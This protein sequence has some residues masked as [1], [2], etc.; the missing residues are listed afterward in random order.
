VSALPLVA[1]L[2]AC[3][4]SDARQRARYLEAMELISR[5]PETAWARCAA[6]RDPSLAGDCALSAVEAMAAG[7][8]ESTADLLARCARL[9]EARDR[10]ECAFQVGERRD[11]PEACAAAGAFADDCRLHLLSASM[12][13]W[14]PA[15]TGPADP[16]GLAALAQQTHRVGLPEGDLRAASAMFRALLDRQPVLDRGACLPLASPWREAC[17]HTGLV[18]FEDRLNQARDRGVLPCP[19]E[20]LPASLAHSPDS[21]LDAAQARRPPNGACPPGEAP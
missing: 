16:A 4:S 18:L 15:S 10:D 9:A 20:P 3:G 2:W 19:G 1:A 6:L 21:E 11:D 14:L 5:D 8:S 7:G 17:W 12:P 13:R